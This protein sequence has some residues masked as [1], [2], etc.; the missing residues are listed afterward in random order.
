MR[1]TE[2]P[3]SDL[4]AW[5][6]LNDVTLYDISVQDVEHKGFG[7]IADRALSSEEAFIPMLLRVPKDLILSAEAVKKHAHVDKHF[8]DLL[9]AAGDVVRHDL[10]HA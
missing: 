8:N 1:R 2:L 7:F 9:T 6:K 10:P 3:I 5:T 4:P